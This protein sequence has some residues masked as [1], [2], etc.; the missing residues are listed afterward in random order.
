M[1]S[2]RSGWPARTWVSRAS[3]IAVSIASEPEPEKKTRASAIGVSATMR[4]RRAAR[5]GALV[6]GSK[7]EYA[8]IVRICRRR[9]R[10]S[11]L[12]RGRS[13]ST[14]G[15]P[16]RRSTRCR[17]LSHRSAPSPRA[18]GDEISRVS[19]WRTDA[20][21]SRASLRQT[22]NHGR[23]CIGARPIRTLQVAAANG[24]R[25]SGRDSASRPVHAQ[26]R[27]DHPRRHTRRPNS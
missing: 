12:A 6:N 15:S 4:A 11:P 13:G 25:R 20:G 24:R 26:A 16:W 10:R 3:F 21:R 9:R 19:A 17:R 1:I 23:S 8:A 2:R 14:T 5:P 18:I 22:R 7:H 27:C